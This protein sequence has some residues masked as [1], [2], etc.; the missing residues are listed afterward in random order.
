MKQKRKISLLIALAMMLTVFAIPTLSYGASED[1]VKYGIVPAG[2]KEMPDYLDIGRTLDL[3]VKSNPASSVNQNEWKWRLY[4]YDSSSFDIDDKKTSEDIATIDPNT[5]VLTARSEGQVHIYAEKTDP[6][7]TSGDA[8]RE[9]DV[10]LNIGYLED[11]Y[12]YTDGVSYNIRLYPNKT[13]KL[14]KISFDFRSDSRDGKKA[15]ASET[16]VI[17]SQYVIDNPAW[18]SDPSE[19]DEKHHGTYKITSI[20]PEA[21]SSKVVKSIIVPDTMTTI[22]NYALGY[23]IVSTDKWNETTKQYD[24][25]YNKVAGVTIYGT[26]NNSAAAK[27]AKANGFAYK[28]MNVKPVAVTSKP[29]KVANVKAKA[30][31]KRMTVTWKRDK[32]V[33]GY[34]ITYA[35]KKNF[36]KAKNVA[37]TKNK[38]TKKVIKKLK[39]GKK[40]YV[41]VRAYKKSGNKKVY[42]AYSK[43]KTVKIK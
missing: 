34:Q 13:A 43:V 41:K 6:T 26:S 37:I 4:G 16:L 11:K 40:Y 29:K 7:V 22:G 32:N 27:Y 17:P 10:Y 33:K 39:T 35:Q 20:I 3:N 28:N 9:V 31:K 19:F 14:G 42:G 21:A 8:D 25:T 30:G 36:K 38:T 23:H 5:G 1:G 2:A 15:I 18:D 24:K 12:A